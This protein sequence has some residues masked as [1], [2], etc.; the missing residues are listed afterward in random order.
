ME[1]SIQLLRLQQQVNTLH[2]IIHT[3]TDATIDPASVQ[4]LQ[5]QNAHLRLS[6]A[7]LEYRIQILL[8]SLN[9]RDAVLSP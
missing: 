5:Q 1:F 4:H 2:D 3:N 6:V 9:S 8:C 7:K